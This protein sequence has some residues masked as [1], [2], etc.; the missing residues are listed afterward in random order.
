MAN[1]SA[2]FREIKLHWLSKRSTVEDRCLFLWNVLS[3]N[4]EIAAT[5]VTILV[6]KDD[7]DE[8]GLPLHHFISYRKPKNDDAHEHP[9]LVELYNLSQH[10][11]HSVPYF[12][13]CI[14]FLVRDSQ[15]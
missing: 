5:E 1:S 10:V 15:I 14:T 7:E 8:K 11:N 13:L 9:G 12:T 2:D 6:S 3:R 4:K